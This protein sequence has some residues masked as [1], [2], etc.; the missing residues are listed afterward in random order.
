MTNIRGLVAALPWVLTCATACGDDAGTA[1]TCTAGPY[2]STLPI[3]LDSISAVKPLGEIHPPGDILPNAQTGFSMQGPEVPVIAPG[4]IR[5]R[6]VERTTWLE[7]P[8]R[9]GH[10]DY[11]VEFTVA[12]CEPIHGTFAHLVSLAPD[13]E[14]LLT[15]E[16]CEE[17]TVQD[18]RIVN[19]KTRRAASLAAGDPV[20]TAG[21]GPTATGLD[22]DLF[23]T[24]HRAEFISADRY[25]AHYVQGICM[26]PLFEE[27]MASQLLE[28]VSHRGVQR[29]AEPRCGTQ[30][31][32]VPGSA[33]GMWV[34][35]GKDVAYHH[36][37]TEAF[38]VLA[39][40]VIL[41][42]ELQVIG[43]ADPRLNPE[44]LHTFPR[45]AA[46]RVNLDFAAVAPDGTL[47]CYTAEPNDLGVDFPGWDEQS[48]FLA[49][50]VDGAL[51]IE[52]RT[53]GSGASPC[54][55]EPSS[56]A[57]GSD[58]PTYMR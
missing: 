27:P 47:Y 35:E 38:L 58:A 23:D 4:P 21:G 25:A 24:R 52:R 2:F 22:F 8:F 10:S 50:G 13:L 11:A 31:V 37:D 12:G 6:S 45:E 16:D 54:D 56:W 14:A 20:G 30:E 9:Q 55:G 36:A 40:H 42:D 41:P 3:P 49:L 15:E 51:T 17:S 19:C 57:F 53:H 18:E 34:A 44:H 26:Q 28:L 46:G 39:P 5:V 33:Q 1:N 48:F 32:D 29:T 43:A 7:S